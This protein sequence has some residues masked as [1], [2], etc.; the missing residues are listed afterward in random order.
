MTPRFEQKYIIDPET[1]P[2]PDGMQVDHLGRNRAFFT[3]GHLEAVSQRENLRSG[4][5]RTKSVCPRGHEYDYF[6]PSNGSRRCSACDK[7]HAD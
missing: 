1:E 6:Q 5:L 4:V 7:L 2:S 3:R